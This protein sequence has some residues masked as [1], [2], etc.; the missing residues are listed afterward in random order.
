[1]YILQ[2]VLLMYW[3]IF[4][5][6]LNSQNLITDN[7]HYFEDPIPAKRWHVSL[8]SC[9]KGEVGDLFNFWLSI[10]KY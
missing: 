4:P 10:V 1:M 8:Y 9:M 7:A 6:M 3:N 5:C 2:I